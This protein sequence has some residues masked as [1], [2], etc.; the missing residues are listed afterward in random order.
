MSYIDSYEAQGLKDNI[1]KYM[2]EERYNKVVFYLDLLLDPANSYDSSAESD[3]A[4]FV[5][6]FCGFISQTRKYVGHQNELVEILEAYCD[7]DK[8]SYGA[9]KARLLAVLATMHKNF[10]NNDKA[11]ILFD[12]AIKVADCNIKTSKT[13]PKHYFDKIRILALMGGQKEEI[14]NLLERLK[15]V[16]EI[17]GDY[18]YY[19]WAKDYKDGKANLPSSMPS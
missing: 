15:M 14:G 16:S 8:Y 9:E 6:R 10:K 12:K 1:I 4:G 3:V 17:E 7:N 18:F 5:E 13:N 2:R 19:D 11:Q